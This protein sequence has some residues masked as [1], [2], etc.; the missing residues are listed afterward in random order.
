MTLPHIEGVARAIASDTH[1]PFEAVEKMCEETWTQFS[2]GARIMDYLP[3]L[4]AR[5]VRESLRNNTS[6][7]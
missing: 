2:E 4:V 5:R 7:T 6:Q 3:V 1:A